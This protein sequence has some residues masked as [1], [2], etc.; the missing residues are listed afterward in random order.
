M[1]AILTSSISSI[2]YRL[3][4]Q[5]HITASGILSISPPSHTVSV[6]RSVP[7]LM[8]KKRR[9]YRVS[10]ART[11]NLT[12]QQVSH[13]NHDTKPPSIVTPLSIH[14]LS[15]FTDD[16]LHTIS[17]INDTLRDCCMISQEKEDA[18]LLSAS[19]VIFL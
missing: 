19:K 15:P 2:I 3:L 7:V 8:K 17:V 16:E 14:D 4:N 13:R 5:L 6:M 12:P 10:P 9:K 11:C 18:S 1:V